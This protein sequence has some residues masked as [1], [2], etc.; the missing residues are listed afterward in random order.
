MAKKK[1]VTLYMD[2][3]IHRNLNIYAVSADPKKS[4]SELVEDLV[5]DYLWRQASQLRHDQRRSTD[6][7]ESGSDEADV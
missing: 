3:K 4:M 2:E 6:S 7:K 5:R 1:R